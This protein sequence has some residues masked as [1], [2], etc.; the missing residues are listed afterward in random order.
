MADLREF[1]KVAAIVAA[2]TIG[3][4]VFALPYVVAHAGWLVTI[5]YFIA[6]A[7]VIAVAHIVYFKTLES[8][9]ARSRLLGL[10][11]NHFGMIGF[12]VG[13]IA[14]VIGLLMSIIV[15]LILGPQL[16]RLIFPMV[17]SAVA[18]FLFWL[19]IAVPV[20][21]GDEG[22]VHLEEFGIFCVAAVI[23]F[24]FATG[25]PVHA[26]MVA[27]LI[28]IHYFFLPLGAILFALAG[29][30]SVE[31]IYGTRQ[32][33][34]PAVRAGSRGMLWIAFIIGTL[35]AAALYFLFA[36]GIVGSASQITSD[37]VSGLMNWPSWK[38]DFIAIIGLL[39]IWTVSMPITRELRNAFEKDLRWRSIP[40]RFVIVLAPLAAVLSGFNDFL[41]VVSIAG[42][43][44][45]SMQYLLIIAVGAR[46]LALSRP[47]KIVLGIA[48]S[49]FVFAV[50]YSVY[51]FLG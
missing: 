20:F 12:W 44:F 7:A 28:D 15:Y 47:Q 3:I 16:V 49:V 39:A 35:F 14:I 9:G 38:K 41:V 32:R 42:G 33:S 48:G 25:R 1:L 6:F 23:L 50:I 17:P 4:G 18:L 51:G 8:V 22:A 36:M 2:A 31:S 29:W 5:C 40:A 26:F 45:L 10:A 11:R 27:P 13:F 34:D 19:F 37:T 24:V 43:V 30:T 21:L 46:S